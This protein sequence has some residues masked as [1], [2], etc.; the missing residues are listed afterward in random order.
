VP[1]LLS[2]IARAVRV[3]ALAAARRTGLMDAIA[4][5]D[6][7]R[8]RLLIVCYHG[9]SIADEHRWDPQLYMSPEQLR[10]RFEQLRDGGYQVLPLSEAT[11]R[12]RAGTL[13]AKSI[14]LTFDDGF[15]DFAIRAVPL[16][17]EFGFP[18]T[19]YL[20]T[21]YMH[22][23]R[24]VFNLVVPYLLWRAAGREAP[25]HGVAG[26]TSVDARTPSA[27]ARTANAVLDA[28]IRGGL[29]TVEKD[30]VA[31]RVADALGLDYDAL[32]ASRALQ[33][34]SP[35]EV[36]ALP[37]FV[38]VQLHTH[39]HRTPDDRGAF[40]REVLE[41]RDEIARARPAG[42]SPA[43]FCY[44]SGRY[45]E[46]QLP[47]L[48][49]LGVRTATTCVPALATDDA[50]PLLLPRFVDTMSVTP[51]EFA[52]WTSGVSEL[53]PRRSHRPAA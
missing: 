6:W 36:A 7:R 29:S 1:V 39:R 23:R 32:L 45:A 13:P 20:T 42:N 37:A 46:A 27:R 21:H 22:H 5:S 53:L 35:A 10:E 3:S 28:V 51:A 48:R 18:A 16:L 34:L 11:T 17:A 31:R 44:P 38:D 41:N 12:L 8:R 30:A 47:W 15:A 4:A 25:L 2:T 26:V 50:E 49:E 52:G 24:P 43:H 19:L 9:V 33:L 14:C 40:D